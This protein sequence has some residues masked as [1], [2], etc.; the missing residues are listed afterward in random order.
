MIGSSLGFLI[1]NIL[2]ANNTRDIR[3][4]GKAS[5]KTQ[6]MLLGIKGSINQ[7]IILG[8]GAYL[9]ITLTVIFGILHPLSLL[10]W[11]SFPLL[12]NNIKEVRLASIEKPELIKDLDGKSAQLVMIFSLL[13]AISNF[14]AG[15]L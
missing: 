1:V 14:I 2:H 15:L 7:Y 3:D 8:V 12:I 13:L 11:L 10:V 6:A 4:D 5:I 9:I